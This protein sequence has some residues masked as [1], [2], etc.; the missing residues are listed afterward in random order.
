MPPQSGDAASD[1]AQSDMMFIGD[2]CSVGSCRQV[3]FLPFVCNG[4]KRTY[5]LDHRGASAHE[6]THAGTCSGRRQEEASRT[7]TLLPRVPTHLSPSRSLGTDVTVIVCPLCAATCRV[8][9]GEDVNAAFARHAAD[10]KL[11]T[12][13]EYAARTT[14]PRCGAPSCRE[15]LVFSNCVTC[16]RC[17][18]KTCL[19][20]RWAD[21]HA[22]GSVRPS[23]QPPTSASGAAGAAAMARLGLGGAKAA[24]ARTGAAPARTAEVCPTCS[25]TCDDVATLVAHCETAHA[26]AGSSGRGGPPAHRPA[27]PMRSGGMGRE[28]CPHCGARFTDVIALVEHHRHSHEAGT[29]PPGDGGAACHVC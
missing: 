12:P 3:D 2:H 9:P 4:C 29:R 13:A 24:P 7:T 20:H 5:C 16:K 19:K 26:A 23:S 25:F 28:V 1:V 17:G 18:V 22:C 21:D 11:C 10:S 14:K 15:K 27:S 6:C 8:R